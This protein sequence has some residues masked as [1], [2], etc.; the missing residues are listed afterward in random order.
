MFIC[1]ISFLDKDWLTKNNHNIFEFDKIKIW[2]FLKTNNFFFFFIQ[3]RYCNF[4][5]YNLALACQ[6][7]LLSQDQNK[8]VRRV[9]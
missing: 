9:C 7:K 4:N 2:T 5:T 6:I 1:N 3:N 8:Y